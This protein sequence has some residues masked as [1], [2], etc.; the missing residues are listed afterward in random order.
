VRYRKSTW[1]LIIWTG[2]MAAWLISGMV[3]VSNNAN[4]TGDYSSYCQAGTAIGA[5]IGIVFIGGLWFM[6]F[7]VGSIIWFASKPKAA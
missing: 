4:C 1:G 2:L 5:G 7:I 6:G 3:N